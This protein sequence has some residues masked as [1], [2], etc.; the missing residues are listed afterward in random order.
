MTELVSAPR[1]ESGHQGLME[2]KGQIM[3]GSTSWNLRFRVRNYS[4]HFTRKVTLS[5]LDFTRNSP[6]V[7]RGE[8]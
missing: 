1:M 8:F 3:R 4:R 2:E 6:V 7:A 5:K